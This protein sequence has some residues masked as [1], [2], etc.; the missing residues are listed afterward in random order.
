MKT[1]FYA[2]CVLQFCLIFILII[3]LVFGRFHYLPD[4]TL[5]AIQNGV[6][7]FLTPIMLY[8][9]KRYLSVQ[10]KSH[11][12][13]ETID[14]IREFNLS[15]RAQRHDFINHM[16]IVYGLIEMD[17]YDEAKKYL[18][19]IYGDLEAVNRFSRTQDVAVNAL[20]QAKYT[21]AVRR[22]IV[23]GFDITTNLSGLAMPSLEICRV[24]SNIIDNG[25]YSAERFEGE[26]RLDI[27]INETVNRF[28]FKVTNTGETIPAEIM[29]KIFTAGFTTKGNQGEG[30]GLYITKG[31]VEKYGGTIS[32][33][34]KNNLTETVVAIP[35]EKHSAL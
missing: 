30:M 13:S 17:E 4:G 14:N 25:I 6:I 19:K 5:S 20:L 27:I 33:S 34:S 21:S 1:F 18:K 26:K 11:T 16:Q 3:N 9:M 31:I 12:Q 28:M 23:M 7:I 10:A 2:I 35:K 8:Q 22:F 32:V 24:I 15:L 29:G